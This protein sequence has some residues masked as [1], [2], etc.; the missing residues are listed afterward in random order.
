MCVVC[1]T[2]LV[3]FKINYYSHLQRSKV[4]L[5]EYR[6]IVGDLEGGGSVAVAVGV[7]D[8]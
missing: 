2:F 8:M 1:A 3:Y 4:K 5:S 6:K 7:S